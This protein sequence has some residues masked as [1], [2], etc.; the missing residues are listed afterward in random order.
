MYVQL[1]NQQE[2]TYDTNELS[3]WFMMDMQQA[4]EHLLYCVKLQN[5][6]GLFL[7]GFFHNVIR[8]VSSGAGTFE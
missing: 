6:F 3:L 4:E 1:K 8:L 7:S 5:P 2:V